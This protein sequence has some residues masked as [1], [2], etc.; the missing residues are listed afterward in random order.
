MDHRCPDIRTAFT[1]GVV[2]PGSY[3]ITPQGQ[4]L[5]LEALG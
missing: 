3:R 1:A 4:Q 5:L 2:D